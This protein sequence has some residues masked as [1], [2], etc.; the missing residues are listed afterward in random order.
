MIRVHQCHL[1]PPTENAAIVRAQMR[2]A[3]NYR[4]DHV[5]IERGRRHA[6]RALHA[7]SPD[8]AW[9][10]E[11][12]RVATKSDRKARFADLDKARSYAE[13]TI[14]SEEYEDWVYALRD[15]PDYETYDL[16]AL[17]PSG[18]EWQRIRALDHQIR[19]DA[20]ALTQT[21]WGNYLTIEQS[22]GQ[23]RETPLY[24]LDGLSP[25]DPKFQRWPRIEYDSHGVGEPRG[26]GQVGIQ[27]QRGL[28]VSGLSGGAMAL[29]SLERR[30]CKRATER[31]G[32]AG[33]RTSQPLDES[34]KRRDLS[35]ATD[36]RIRLVEGPNGPRGYPTW[37]LWL[38]LESDGLAPVWG[39]WPLLMHRPIPAGAIVDGA[40]VE[41][42]IK[43][44]RV[45][46]RTVGT[47]E[48]WSCELTIDTPGEHPHTLDQTLKDAIAVELLWTPIDG[49][50]IRAATW[51]D[52]TGKR[53]E[54]V[55]EARF[56]RGMR[57]ASDLRSL[58]DILLNELRPQ[59]ALLLR[60][61][62]DTLPRWLVE[63]GNTLLL[64][65]SPERFL[66]LAKRWRAEK[67]DAA[68]EAYEL[69]QAWEL[70]NNHLLDYEV[71]ARRGRL[72]WRKNFYRNLAAQWARRYK[73]VLLPDRD[74]SK[75]AIFGAESE[76][77]FLTS[78]QELRFVL[79]QAFGPDAIDVGWFGPHGVID[80][81][82]ENADV[83]EWKQQAIEQWRD[84]KIRVR[85]RKRKKKSDVSGKVGGAWAARK[86]RK[87]TRRVESESARNADDK[88]AE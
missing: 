87:V 61:S 28:A 82:D 29:R 15:L 51:F 56:V 81:G 6:V 52:S 25:L 5:A 60:E 47:R 58:R 23:V 12:L 62:K 85:A 24:D 33:P 18:T 2:M 37:T 69:L 8:V 64:W 67:C 83:P 38:R 11:A 14:P 9:C 26:D 17:D 7:R 84:G 22:A 46:C 31:D 34:A 63:A 74:L 39:H 45:S 13:R 57:K 36:T 55:L 49:D 40:F 77:R 32:T 72:H 42:K 27:L 20:R 88:C 44:A 59:L 50:R 19:R 41:T 16:S 65:R 75:E 68:R 80:V 73:A 66:N 86:E 1:Q 30:N 48:I 35:G 76:W 53:G 21:Y 78:P 54:I 3:H 70:R 79:Q 43:W 71:G 4:N 10:A